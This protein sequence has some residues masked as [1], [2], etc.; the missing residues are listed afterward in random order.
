MKSNRL[1]RSWTGGVVKLISLALDFLFP[2]IC[3]LCG[4]KD[5]YHVGCF[6]C[7]DC[8]NS[9]SFISHPVCVRCGRPFLTEA[10]RDHVCGNCL[11]QEPY[12][13]LVRALGRYEGALETIIHNL[14]YKQKFSMVNL[15]SFLLDHMHNHSITFPSYDLLIP[16]PLHRSRLRQRGFNQTV[17]LGNILKKKYHL[18]LHTSILQRIAHTLPQVTLP[19]KARKVNMQN[20]FK[21]K[22]PRSVEGKTILL[23]DDVYTTGATMNEC[24]RILK[25]SGASRVDGFVIARAV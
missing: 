7:K 25:K 12:F 3:L 13:N 19:V 14:K 23:L 18:P 22:E 5:I 6:I 17:I 24:A 16:V 15:L 8:L 11:T 10:T 20:A 21:V 9:I 1:T 2:P 4:S